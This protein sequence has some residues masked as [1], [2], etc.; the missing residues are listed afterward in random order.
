MVASKKRLRVVYVHMRV[1]Y[2]NREKESEEERGRE[3]DGVTEGIHEQR[4]KT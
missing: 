1:G 4:K 3:T 2:W